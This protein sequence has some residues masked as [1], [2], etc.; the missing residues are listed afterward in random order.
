MKNQISK[1]F[2]LFFVFFYLFQMS[3]GKF[4]NNL[5]GYQDAGHNYFYIWEYTWFRIFAVAVPII[6]VLIYRIFLHENECLT[7]RNR[8]AVYLS[9]AIILIVDIIHIVD[10]PSY[11]YLVIIFLGCVFM[12][13]YYWKT[14]RV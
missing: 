1:N 7:K 11:I 4:I 12:L 13:L 2:H 3:I 10:L 6:L 14:S 5:L 9:A 8:A